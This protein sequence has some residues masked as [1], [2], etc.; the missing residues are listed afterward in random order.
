MTG[1]SEVV[2]N[3]PIPGPKGGF[4]FAGDGNL[5]AV[6]DGSLQF[7]TFNGR[8]LSPGWSLPFMSPTPS[9]LNAERIQP[10]VLA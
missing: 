8:A 9:L 5:I 2:Q 10:G 4:F 3:L 7:W 1:R 6:E